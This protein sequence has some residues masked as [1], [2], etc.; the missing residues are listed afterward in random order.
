MDNTAKENEGRHW[1]YWFEIPCA[2]FER[3]KKFYE[4]IFNMKIAST[5]FG[6]IKMGIFPHRDSG[7]AIVESA[8]HRPG[9]DGPMIYLEAEP[10]LTHVLELVIEAGGQII[11][12]KK[13]IS[14]EHG[15]SALVI[16]SEGNRL[17]LHSS[18]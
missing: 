1:V 15:Y 5:E 11:Q 12:D 4:T 14:E 9:P 16:D 3:A 18:K 10:D 13:L 6:D 17:A 2:D 8:F 7:G